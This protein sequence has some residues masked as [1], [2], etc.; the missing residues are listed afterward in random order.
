MH[1]PQEVDDEVQVNVLEEEADKDLV[2]D[3]EMGLDKY[4][5]EN[6]V[7][8]GMGLVILRK[9]VELKWMIW[10]ILVIILLWKKLEMRS[11]LYQV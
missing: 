7:N 1:P 4:D 3:E 10:K 9:L 8:I 6:N 2:E 5:M 11:Y